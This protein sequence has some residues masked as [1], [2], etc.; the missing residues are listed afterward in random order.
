LVG[1]LRGWDLDKCVAVA[2]AVG[3]LVVTKHGAITALPYKDELNKFL[4]NQG[5]N[6]RI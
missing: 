6:I 3:A 2:N 5:L 4:E 1:L